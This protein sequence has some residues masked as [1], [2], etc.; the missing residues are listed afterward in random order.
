MADIISFETG[1]KTYM[2]NDKCE[3]SFN[4][5]DINFLRQL[6]SVAEELDKRQ[7]E[8]RA[9]AQ[10]REDGKRLFV[11]AQEADKDMREIIDGLF[12]KPVCADLFGNLSVFAVGDGF[13]LW[14]N[15]LYAIVDKM[16]DSLLAEKQ[17]AQT[18]IRKYSEKY[19]RT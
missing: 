1:L 9:E 10:K 12:G 7:E 13:P 4:P 17:R 8:F 19:K 5:G 6:Y 18:R 11:L 16:D 3:V 15:L 2:L 14:A